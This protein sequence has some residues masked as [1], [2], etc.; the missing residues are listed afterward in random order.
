MPH[1]V[2]VC[3]FCSTMPGCN[4][5]LNPL[6]ASCGKIKSSTKDIVCPLACLII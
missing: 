4:R 1:D 3:I 2:F 6:S 5:L